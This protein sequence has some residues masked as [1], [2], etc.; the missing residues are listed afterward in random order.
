MNQTISDEDFGPFSMKIKKEN[1]NFDVYSDDE[2]GNDYY[3]Y[4]K[5]KTESKLDVI[6][7]KS[8]IV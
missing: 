5:S 2:Y 7:D 3:P 1:K 6:I 8:N 4:N